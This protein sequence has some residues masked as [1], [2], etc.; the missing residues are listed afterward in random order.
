MELRVLRYFLTVAELGS[1]TRAAERLHVTQPTLSRQLM[2]LEE[3]LRHP[4]FNRSYHRLTLTPEGRLLRRRA[5]DILQL[6]GKAESEITHMGRQLSGDVYIGAGEFDAMEEVAAAIHSIRL[7][8]PG[9]RFHMTD[10]TALNVFEQLDGGLLDFGVVIQP[11]DTSRYESVD[12]PGESEWGLV[13]RKDSPLAAK[14]S[15]TYEDIADV[16]L[17]GSRASAGGATR[18]YWYGYPGWLAEKAPRLRIAGT[19]NLSYNSTFLVARSGVPMLCIYQRV[20]L[21]NHP[22]LCFRP[23]SPRIVSTH[24]LIYR[25]GQLFSPAA[26]LFLDHFK[27]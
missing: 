2:D 17:L 26:Q 23:F 3:E 25:R 16:P 11:A 6:V 19:M 15:L 8:H 13:L 14:E 5:E 20:L 10:A 4:L 12:L 18:K 24:S 9:V 22:V 27:P 21:Q 1:I 7:Q